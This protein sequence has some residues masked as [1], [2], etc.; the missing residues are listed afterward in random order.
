M[1]NTVEKLAEKI[2]IKGEVRLN[3][4]MAEHTSFGIGGPADIY[5]V[6]HNEDDL[7]ELLLFARQ[8]SFPYRIV[9]GGA[10]ILV[11]DG[12]IRGLVIDTTSLSEIRRSGESLIVDAGASMSEVASRA[13]KEK[14][15]GLEFLYKM[16]GSAGGAVWMNARCYGKS[17]SDVLSWVDY[18]DEEGHR[19]RLSMPDPRFAY[20]SSPFQGGGAAIHRLSL[21]LYSDSQDHIREK[22][23]EVYRDR[24]EKGHFE[25]PSAGS[26]FKN[27]RNIGKPT[28]VL[29]DELGL[30][31]LRRGE[32]QIAPYHANIIINLGAAK[33]EDVRLL[34][35]EAKEQARERLGVELE[36]ELQFI[37]EWEETK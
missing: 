27:D 6:P 28:G 9:G 24:K 23:E 32:A 4:I 35:E 2:N 13:E 22:M 5:A 30:K 12:G 18:L 14:L 36:T 15:G 3:E 33:A 7:R 31:G 29:L 34:V 1:S 25:Y 20:K 10:N 16:P 26:V 8:T 37:G 21:S 11:A 19:Q 17:I